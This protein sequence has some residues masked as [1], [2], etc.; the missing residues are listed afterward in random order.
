MLVAALLW[1]PLHLCALRDGSP[2]AP[3]HSLMEHQKPPPVN[4]SINNLSLSLLADSCLCACKIQLGCRGA[5]WPAL[6]PASV[7]F[8]LQ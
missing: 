6:L 2:E 8:H 1:C 7:T 4:T 5:G 3:T